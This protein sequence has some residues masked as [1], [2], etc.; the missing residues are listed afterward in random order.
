MIVELSSVHVTSSNFPEALSQT[1]LLS[2][3]LAT[4]DLENVNF[5]YSL[6]NIPIPSNQEYLLELIN[7]SEVFVNSLRWHCYFFL[8]PDKKPNAKET[9]GFK[10]T[11]SAPKVDTSILFKKN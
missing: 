3:L 11:K 2:T 1:G 6:K 4:M 9:Y 10:S 7:S 5:G 8:N